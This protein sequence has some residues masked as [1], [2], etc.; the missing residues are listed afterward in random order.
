MPAILAVQ[1]HSVNLA[2]RCRVLLR[3]FMPEPAYSLILGLW[4]LIIKYILWLS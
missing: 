4:A 1:T 2:L 3:E